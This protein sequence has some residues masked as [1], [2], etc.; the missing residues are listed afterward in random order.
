MEHCKNAIAD[1]DRKNSEKLCCNIES[2][3]EHL[4]IVVRACQK[5]DTSKMVDISQTCDECGCRTDKRM[6][7]HCSKAKDAQKQNTLVDS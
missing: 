3:K 4:N 1:P 7:P 2:R 5:H 6:L